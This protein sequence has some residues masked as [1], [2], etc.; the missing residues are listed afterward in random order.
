METIKIYVKGG[1]VC[2]VENLP[3][4]FEYEIIDYD[5]SEDNKN[6]SNNND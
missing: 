6:E 4:N 1:V 3:E 2:D 5:I